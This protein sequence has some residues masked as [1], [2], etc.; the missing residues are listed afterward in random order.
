MKK[1]P[2]KPSIETL[3]NGFGEIDEDHLSIEAH[4]NI[5]V[6]EIE[7]NLVA[8]KSYIEDL[9]SF[10]NVQFRLSPYLHILKMKGYSLEDVAWKKDSLKLPRK[11]GAVA[12]NI[13]FILTFTCEPYAVQAYRD[14]IMEMLKAFDSFLND[15]QQ[16]EEYKIVFVPQDMTSV[17]SERKLKTF[18]AITVARQIGV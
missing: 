11:S 6:P 3:L 1:F 9:F 18:N 2:L 8:Y 7:T 10:Q 4:F 5:F 16:T 15:L 13:G 12:E 17:R 14:V